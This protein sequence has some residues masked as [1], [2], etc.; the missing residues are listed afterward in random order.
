MGKQPTAAEREEKAYRT[1]R[2]FWEEHG[3]GLREAN[4]A[5]TRKHDFVRKMGG[6][7]EDIG[8]GREKGTV[9]ARIRDILGEQRMY[10]IQFECCLDEF[11]R[12][13]GA[14]RL[15]DTILQH[16][17]IQHMTIKKPCI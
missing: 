12:Y 8:E 10:M 9:H 2:A 5:G 1:V 14:S 16:A 3:A 13:L 15:L 6:L 4:G 17:F 11:N 7:H